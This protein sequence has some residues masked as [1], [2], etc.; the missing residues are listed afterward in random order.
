MFLGVGDGV[1]VKVVVRSALLDEGVKELKDIELGE[2]VGEA[3][4]LY[5]YLFLLQ[6]GYLIV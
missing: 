1:V 3:D 2:F 5:P 4:G 6:H